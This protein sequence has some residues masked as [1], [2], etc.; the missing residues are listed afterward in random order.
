MA[1]QK[2]DDQHEHTFSSYVRIRDAVLKTYL[3]RW[4]IGRSGERGSGISVLPARYD[5]NDDD[6][7]Y[8]YMYEVHT[9]SLQTFFVWALK[10]V[11]DSWKFTVLLLYIVWDD[12]LTFMISA[13]NEQLQQ[14]LEYTLLKPDCHS[15]WISKMQ[16]DTLEERYAIKFCFK[17]GKMLQKRM[18]CFRLL[19]DHLARIEHQFFSGI[20]DSRIALMKVVSVSGFLC[21]WT[22]YI[23]VFCIVVSWLF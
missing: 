1:V 15:W 23:F 10:I 21:I 5:D 22:F 18:E 12:G 2:R 9:I 19:F 16:F 13:S 7:I 8:I 20:G 11:V 3:G 6:D 4:T 14:K 17:L